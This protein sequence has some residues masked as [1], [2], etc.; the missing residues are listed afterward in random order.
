MDLHPHAD[1]S[2]ML[3]SLKQTL[4]ELKAQV[5]SEYQNSEADQENAG[6]HPQLAAKPQ[7]GH[8]L[9]GK[10]S[11]PMHHESAAQ[12]QHREPLLS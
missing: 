10:F 8:Q 9:D 7:K 11:I 3:S 2:P 1:P 12:I 4:Q 6:F 5:G